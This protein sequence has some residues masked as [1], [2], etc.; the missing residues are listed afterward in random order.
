MLLNPVLGLPDGDHQR[1]P[2]RY[3]AS[4]P[5]AHGD[6]PGRRARSGAAAGQLWQ[7]GRLAYLDVG[8]I[9]WHGSFP[10]HELRLLNNGH[11]VPPAPFSPEVER[12][13]ENSGSRQDDDDSHHLEIDPPDVKLD[14]ER[15]YRAQDDEEESGPDAH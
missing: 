10:V 11:G 1:R 4:A 7:A 12:E 13:E 3:A 14:R 9:G 15:E 6:T 2:T 8:W 5:G